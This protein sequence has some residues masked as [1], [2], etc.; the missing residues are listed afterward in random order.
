MRITE[1]NFNIRHG[2]SLVNSSVYEIIPDLKEEEKTKLN[3]FDW[4]KEFPTIFDKGGFSAV[5]GNPPYVRGDS[6]KI[7]KPYLAEKYHVYNGVAD[8]YT[9]FCEQALNILQE[10]GR[11]GFITSNKWL[12]ARYGNKLRNLLRNYTKI[13]NIIDFKGKKLFEG[14]SVDTSIMLVSKEKP[15][16]NKIKIGYKKLNNEE[17]KIP[18]NN[19]QEKGFYLQKPE[20]LNIKNKMEEIGT[21]LN[22]WDVNIYGG[23]LTGYNEAF[24]IDTPTKEELCKQDPKSAEIIKPILRGRDVGRYSYNWKGLWLIFTK[25]GIDIKNY[26]VIETYLKQF[27]KQIKPKNPKLSS[28]TG[29][30]PGTYKWYEIQDNIAYYKE[31]EKEKIIWQEI[32]SENPFHWDKGYFYQEASLF[33]MTNASK[34]LLT[35]LNSKIQLFYLSRIAYCLGNSGLRWKKIYVEQL[36]IPQLDLTDS[37]QKAHYDKLSKLADEM[38]ELKGKLGTTEDPHNRTKLERHIE[39]TDGRIDQ[40]VYELYGLTEEE[41]KI[42]EE[43]LGKN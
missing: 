10:H 3:P 38:L 33:L 25:R 7:E 2:N 22:E 18:Q 32:S 42:V 12:L 21:P 16:N 14:A 27:Y 1:M 30:K 17:F 11:L 36:P 19:L 6:I 29:R 15:K 23:I 28:K 8:I 13:K 20:I 40:L 41:I 9:Y 31:F 35:I 4:E 5:V 34:Y 37:K 43:E 24:I 26:P 39:A